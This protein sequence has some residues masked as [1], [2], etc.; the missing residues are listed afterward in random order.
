MDA[1]K[2]ILGAASYVPATITRKALEK[3]NPAF[4]KYFSRAVS[5]GIDSNR[6]LDYLTDRMETESQRGYKSDLEKGAATKTL[7]PDEMVSR[8]RISA[9]EMPGKVA[10][11]AL[12]F[13]S[14]VALGGLGENQQTSTLASPAG[15]EPVSGN[16]Q[17]ESSFYMSSL[18]QQFP[19]LFKFV[20]DRISRGEEPKRAAQLSRIHFVSD[21][22][23]LEKMTG[24]KFTDLVEMMF[25]QR[26]G[27]QS[28][29]QPA[30]AQPSPQREAILQG[31]NQLSQLLQR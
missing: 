21:I 22:A 16:E 28:V 20:E 12:S 29:S 18:S 8:S 27:Q 3:I 14:G 26:M 6:A 2:S 23:N 13:G 11:T 5:Y 24:R 1:I 4:G 10:K 19:Q 17:Q 9:S 15:S 7:R 25:G 31:I 30:Q